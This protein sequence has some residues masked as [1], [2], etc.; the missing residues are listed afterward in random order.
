MTFTVY[1]RDGCPYCD[2]VQRVLEL[3][4][5]KYVVYKLGV[6]FDRDEFYLK[7]GQGSTFPRVILDE[8]VIGGCTETVQYLKEQ[9]LV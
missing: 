7:F 1:S 6:D 9:K 2:K 4:E 5:Q 8:K 3:S